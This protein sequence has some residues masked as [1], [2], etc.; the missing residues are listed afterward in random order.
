MAG[1]PSSGRLNYLVPIAP[2]FT[3]FFS[4]FIIESVYK[5]VSS[6]Y[7]LA[8]LVFLT[9]YFSLSSFPGS[10]SELFIFDTLADFLSSM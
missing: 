1:A 6:A 3:Y 7:S 2:V 10:A 8:I 5:K 4:V 9:G